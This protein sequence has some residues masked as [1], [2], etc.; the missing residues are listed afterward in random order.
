MT[1]QKFQ[2]AAAEMLK[3]FTTD[4][5]KKSAVELFYNPNDGAAEALDAVLTT[6][7]ARISQIEFTKFCGT[8]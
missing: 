2:S 3:N 8:F 7:E 6:L 5:L 4:E 1:Q